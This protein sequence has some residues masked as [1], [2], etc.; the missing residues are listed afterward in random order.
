MLTNWNLKI[1]EVKLLNISLKLLE[2]QLN[3][4]VFNEKANK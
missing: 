4:K 2:I 1:S 3:K